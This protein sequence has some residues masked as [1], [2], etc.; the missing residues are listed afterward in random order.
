MAVVLAGFPRTGALA[1]IARTPRDAFF[2]LVSSFVMY[3]WTQCSLG[4]PQNFW[5]FLVVKLLIG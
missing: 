4:S 2:R 3:V 5:P 1:V